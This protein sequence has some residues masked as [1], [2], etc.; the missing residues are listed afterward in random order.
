MDSPAVAPRAAPAARAQTARPAASVVMPFAGEA[1]EAAEAV[2]TLLSLERRPDDEL[3]LADNA[4]TAGTRDG[5]TVV[6]A[7]DERSP[8]H[9]RNAGAAVASSEWILFLDADCRPRPRLLD[10]YFSEPVDESV[11]ALAGEV[12]GEAATGGR[13]TLAARYGAAKSFLSQRAHLAHPYRPRAVAANLLVRRRAF[14][15]VGGFYE[16]LRAAED[17]DFVWRLQQAG[18]RLEPRPQAWVEHRYRATLRD[19]R[20][21]WRGYAAGR[22]WLARRYDGFVPEPALPRALRR[23]GGWAARRYG[24]L[25]RSGAAADATPA[26]NVPEALARSGAAAD[27]TPAPNVPE[28]LARSGAA[29]DATPAPNVP[30]APAP[31]RSRVERGQYLAVDALLALEELAGF[32]LSNR[33]TSAERNRSPKADTSVVF[34]ADRFPSPDDPLIELPSALRGARIEAARRPQAMPAGARQLRIDYREDDGL[35]E[36]LAAAA[37]L[38][39]VHPLR[40]LR[41]AGKRRQGEPS[42]LALAPPVRRLRRAPGAR[43]QPLGGGDAAAVAARVEALAGR[44]AR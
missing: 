32:T 26:P 22:A 44:R 2:A 15:Q 31:K 9:A 7:T 11:G 10:Q 28:A 8:A 12:L 17:T 29:A 4:G 39:V 19:L 16:G 40:C 21:Q 37:L 27:A 1:P 34:V 18:W 41:D 3:I 30:E 42:L 35:A 24:A 5:V 25:A 38:A 33:P 20:R 13:P 36:R 6:L 23:A 14:I 43:V